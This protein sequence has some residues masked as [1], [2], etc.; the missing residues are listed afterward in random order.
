MASTIISETIDA[1]YPVAGVD[2]DTQGFR[3]NFQIIKDN[4]E[5]AKNEIT[6]LQ[7]GTVKLDA[8]NNFQG[9]S[10]LIDVNL[11]QTT[12]EYHNPGTVSSSLN[13]SFLNGHY[14]TIT[15]ASELAGGAESIK[16]TLAD[17]PDREGQAKI[18]VEIFDASD[19]G[20]K[21]VTFDVEG[22]GNIRYSA[23]WPE[24]LQTP[25]WPGDATIDTAPRLLMEFWTYNQGSTVYA[26]YLGSFA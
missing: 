23:D 7:D 6:V 19:S 13:I 18:I 24:T 4:F 8:D 15:L 10:T 17:W 20:N 2:N 21:E 9:D 26:N 16:F 25:T 14:Q 11:T 12:Q 5:K 22:G 1:Q 3:D